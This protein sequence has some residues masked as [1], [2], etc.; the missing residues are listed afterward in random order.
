MAHSR[1]SSMARS[2]AVAAVLALALILNG[3]GSSSQGQS[4]D[5]TT[6]LSVGTIPID[7]EAQVFYAKE[8]GFFEDEGLE[9]E[10]QTISNGSAIASAVQSGDLDIGNSNIVSIA[11]AV[12][13][14][15]PF[16]LVAPGAAYS[17]DAPSTVMMVAGDSPIQSAKDLNGKTVAVN[18]LDNITQVGAETWIEENGGDPSS[19]EF[20]ELPFPQMGAALDEGRVDAAV[21]AEPALTQAESGGA[22]VLGDV[23]SAIADDF[24]ITS[25]F[26]QGNWVEQN[27]E[28]AEKFS[29]A[30]QKA[31]QWANE[32]PEESAQILEQYTEISTETANNM[33]RATNGEEFD[34]SL[35]QP[36]IDSARQVGVLQEPLDAES[37]VPSEAQTD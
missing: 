20:S 6:T 31:S 14:G 19:V 27:P 10:I 25:Y 8:R 1:H 37:L 11:T 3:C 15:L 4:E 35:V 18:G 33:T 28:A 22:R 17:S 13:Q 16:E 21:V 32:H 2:F 23:Y 36:P 24:L 5:G 9:V 7:A 30:I 26:A 12:E 34:P 29:R